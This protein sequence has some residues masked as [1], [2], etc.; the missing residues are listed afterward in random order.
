MFD[1]TC[2]I[3]RS[4]H[5]HYGWPVPYLHS[6]CDHTCGTGRSH[7]IYHG[8]PVPHSCKIFDHHTYIVHQLSMQY[9]PM[10][11]IWEYNFGWVGRT[12]I[13]IPSADHR[14]GPLSWP[15][16]HV[17]RIRC[18][19]IFDWMVCIFSL[20]MRDYIANTIPMRRVY[21]EAW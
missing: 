1:H 15:F 4:H 5:I 8:R 7:H 10:I 6:N 3:G 18:T 13:Y 11:L 19:R 14:M 12:H 9:C 20:N 17:G 21:Y 2:G 16:V